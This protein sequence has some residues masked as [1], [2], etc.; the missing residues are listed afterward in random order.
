MQNY[1]ALRC[2]TVFPG[3]SENYQPLSLWIDR[4]EMVHSTCP[5]LPEAVHDLLEVTRPNSGY[6]EIP[7]MS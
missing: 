6:E 7:L 3:E 4:I 1:H 5:R 2:V